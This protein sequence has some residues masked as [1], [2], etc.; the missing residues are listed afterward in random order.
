MIDIFLTPE[1]MAAL[2]ALIAMEIVLGI[3]N[4]LFI[5]IVTNKLPAE[6]RGRARRIGISLALILRLALLSAVAWLATLTTPLFDLGLSGT[7]GPDGGPGFETAFSGRDLILILGG[8]FLIWKATTEIHEKVTP[9]D[10]VELLSP[11]RA[12]TR[13]GAVIVQ[14]LLLDMVFSVD[15][16]LTAVGMTHHLPIMIVA[17]VIAVAVMMFAAGP[18]ARFVEANPTVVMLA[19]GFLLMIGMMLVAD[20]FGAHVPKGY[21]YAAMAFAAFIEGLNMTRRR[22]L[23]RLNI[24][25]G[26]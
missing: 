4:L 10:N 5:S 13:F 7:P 2:A 16:I 3:D 12:T 17:M 1:N 24:K 15:S 25:D 21:L 8:A 18:V 26:G 6:I 22:R 19:L 14:I 9:G 20:G 11:A 23:E